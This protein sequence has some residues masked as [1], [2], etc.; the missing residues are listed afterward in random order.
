M[1]MSSP[2]RF[3]VGDTVAEDVT[4]IALEA[5]KATD[6]RTLCRWRCNRSSSI[7]KSRRPVSDGS[8]IIEVETIVALPQQP[9][10]QPLKLPHRLS[11]RLRVL[12]PLL[13]P[14]LQVLHLPLPKSTRPLSPE[15]TLSLPPQTGARV[16]RGFGPGQRC[17]LERPFHGRRHQIA[18]CNP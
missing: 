6:G 11:F 14:R 2:L 15:R 16:G 9:L 13:P 18:L 5:D 4:L 7:L 3:Q 10:L 8:A 17:R 12:S 1:W